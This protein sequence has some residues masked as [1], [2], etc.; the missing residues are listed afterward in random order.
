MGSSLGA[1]PK[2]PQPLGLDTVRNLSYFQ[3][4]PF[5]TLPPTEDWAWEGGFA[6]VSTAPA[7]AL[8]LSLGTVSTEWGLSERMPTLPALPSSRG[9][10]LPAAQGLG[11]LEVRKALGPGRVDKKKGN[12]AEMRCPKGLGVSRGR[13]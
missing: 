10:L 3:D 8:M 6:A 12:Q 5:G 1:S 13:P 4:S 9:A 2:H 7:A 11:R